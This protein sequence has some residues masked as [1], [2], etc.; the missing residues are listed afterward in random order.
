MICILHL[1]GQLRFQYLDDND[2]ILEE[3]EEAANETKIVQWS[4]TD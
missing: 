4:T 2:G 1:A 3:E